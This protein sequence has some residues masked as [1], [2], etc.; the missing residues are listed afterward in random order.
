[1]QVSFIQK[2][3][4]VAFGA[5]ALLGA[6][7]NAGHTFAFNEGSGDQDELNPG[8][9]VGTLTGDDTLRGIIT[10]KTD[11]DLFKFTVSAT[12]TFTATVFGRTPTTGTAVALVD[13]Q[14]F[15]F[16]STAAGLEALYANDDRNS[17]NALSRI[18][19]IT[20]A[21][22]DYV[23]GISGFDYDPRNSADQ[24]LFGPASAGLLQ[25]RSAVS[26]NPILANWDTR[27]NKT[28]APGAYRISL[29]SE[30]VPVP[31]PA[32]LPGLAALG[33]SAI[34]KRKAQAAVA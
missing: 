16:K 1:M 22:G 30:I 8:P 23:L 26:G 17:N 5:V 12:S 34:R 13:S 2:S 9:S 25:P 18:A 6:T 28:G 21:A 32:L 19:N 15:L 11:A 4:V 3:I 10:A 31:T 29:E 33:F 27:S 24:Y 14:L 7:A 20:L